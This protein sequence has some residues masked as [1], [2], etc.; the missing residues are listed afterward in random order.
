MRT[1]GI[2]LTLVFGCLTVAPSTL[3]QEERTSGEDLWRTAV[4]PG[5]GLSASFGEGW[6]LREDLPVLFKGWRAKEYGELPAAGVYQSGAR[7]RLAFQRA[8]GAGEVVASV[9]FD[10]RHF[11]I[12]GMP[13]LVGPATGERREID[14][15]FEDEKI[16][17]EGVPVGP[18]LRTIEMEVCSRKLRNRG[19]LTIEDKLKQ[20]RTIRRIRPRTASWSPLAPGQIIAQETLRP[21]VCHGGYDT[22]GVKTAV[23]WANGGKL[24]GEF[25]LLDAERNRQH[26][27]P[28][29]VVYTGRL[30]DAGTHIWGGRNYVADF[31]DFRKPGLYFVRLVVEETKE[32]ADSLVFPIRRGRY[33]ELATK[34]ADWFTYQRCGTEV[35]G[36]HRACHT[37]DAVV[38]LD[39]TKVDVTGGWHDAGDYGKWIGPGTMGIMALTTLHEDFGSEIGA[40]L[41]GMPR[42]VNEAA[43]EAKY[44][45]KGYWD[46]AFHAGFTPDF[47]DVCT[48]LGAPEHEPPRVVSEKECLR[49]DYGITRGPATCLTAAALARAGRL[50]APYDEDLAKRCLAVAREV[51]DRYADFDLAIPENEKWRRTNLSY[52]QSGLLLVAL[53]LGDATGEARFPRDAAERA[54]RILDLQDPEGFFYDDETRTSKTSRTG[55]HLPALYEFLRRNRGTGLAGRIREAFR[56]WAEHVLDL[57]GLSPFGQIGGRA[58]DGTLRNLKPNTNNGRFG[59]LAWALATAARLLGEP[60]YLRAAEEQLQWILGRN[61]ADV[62]MMAGVGRGPGCYHT[63]YCFMEGCEHGVVPGGVTLGIVPGTGGTVELGDTDTKNWVIADVPVDYPLID[64]DVHGWTYAYRTSEYALAKNASFLRAA[65]QIEKALRELR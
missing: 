25:Q 53:E 1:R 44:I 62:S 13:V 61:P 33:L 49:L 5:P 14:Y 55:I 50:V 41:G 31:T 7:L 54:K 17:F 10:P 63:R 37:K 34:A 20:A 56:R 23:V 21:I 15:R 19:E 59:E 43:W 4:A 26:P 28:Q 39:G 3:A 40:M 29:P 32:V 47:E 45:A 24:T 38:K 60:R 30:T 42:Y 48:W 22:E 36:F 2:L 35:P 9:A 18:G 46:G 16:V 11:F 57:G 51:Y 52:L 6:E 58:E 27:A 64:T 65:G 8:P 12:K